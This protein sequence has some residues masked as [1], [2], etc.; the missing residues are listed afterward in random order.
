MQKTAEGQKEVVKLQE[1]TTS[2]A[3][4]QPERDG[5]I[6]ETKQTLKGKYYK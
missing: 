2:V 6:E 3:L 5:K 1:L 4:Q